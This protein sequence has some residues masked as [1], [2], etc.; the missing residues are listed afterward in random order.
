MNSHACVVL[1]VPSYGECLSRAFSRDHYFRRLSCF[2]Q[3]Q[4]THVRHHIGDSH[5]VNGQHHISA[6]QSRQLSRS[7]F[8]DSIDA[9]AFT[10]EEIVGKNP[11]GYLETRR[12]VLVLVFGWGEIPNLFSI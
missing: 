8:R 5:L 4:G 9:H 11:Q 1:L 10:D 3:T 12:A 7:A 2:K 6:F